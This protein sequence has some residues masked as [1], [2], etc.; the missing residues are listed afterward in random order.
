MYQ[1]PARHTFAL[2]MLLVTAVTGADVGG[3]A[4]SI[5]AMPILNMMKKTTLKLSVCAKKLYSM[6]QFATQSEVLG[7]QVAEAER[8]VALWWYYMRIYRGLGRS[9]FHT[10]QRAL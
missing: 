8:S 3:L 2:M 7:A 1:G 6:R 9:M 10:D 5:R 4:E